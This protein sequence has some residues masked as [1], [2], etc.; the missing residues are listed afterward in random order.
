M[1]GQLGGRKHAS[2]N[3]C[4]RTKFDMK[5][6]L[7]VGGGAAGKGGLYQAQEQV[8]DYPPIDTGLQ[9]LNKGSKECVLD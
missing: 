3:A 8:K 7:G 1:R 4:A 5:R 9:R 6:P 2:H